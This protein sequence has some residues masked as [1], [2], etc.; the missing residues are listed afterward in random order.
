MPNHSKNSPV[1]ARFISPLDAFRVTA[2]HQYRCHA[3]P[4][5]EWIDAGLERVLGAHRS[6]CDFVQ[7]RV[8]RDILNLSKSNYFESCKSERR[9]RHLSSLSEQFVHHHAGLALKSN[10][11]FGPDPALNK[12][13]KEFHIY[14]GDG[15]FHAASSHDERD[16][17]GGKNAIGHLYA[18]NLRSQFLSHLALGSDGT[19]RKPHDMKALKKA[20]VDTLR[21]GAG[22]G[23]KVLY[24]WD[25]AGIDF[26]QWFLW[27]HNSGVYFLSRTKRNMKL[28]TPLPIRYDKTDPVNEGVTADE[29]V[30]NSSSRC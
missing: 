22:K 14:A 12:C 19:T 10:D 27:K 16:Y 2:K 23:E 29:N 7:E 11:L 17:K 3:V 9:Y 20:S 1:F 24:V 8:L 15:H 25:R 4:D 5:D 26:R 21:Q 6:G 28:D 30:S 13:L 18:L